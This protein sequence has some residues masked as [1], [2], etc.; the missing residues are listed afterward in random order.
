MVVTDINPCHFNLSRF[1]SDEKELLY[2]EVL[3]IPCRNYYSKFL[4]Q[5]FMSFF[6]F[7]VKS[8]NNSK[9]F[10]HIGITLHFKF[11]VFFGVKCFCRAVVNVLTLLA[12][13]KNTKI[14]FGV[15]FEWEGDAYIVFFDHHTPSGFDI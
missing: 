12:I 8:Q 10:F 14:K 11:L 7:L 4:P 5:L 1:K 9:Q 13:S 3:G 15:A 6:S 2:R